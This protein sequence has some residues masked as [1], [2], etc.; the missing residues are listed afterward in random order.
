MLLCI[1]YHNIRQ[2]VEFYH[3]LQ[4]YRR[5]ALMLGCWRSDP[6]QRPNALDI[7]GI[8]TNNENIIQPL[9]SCPALAQITNC[10]E[11]AELDMSPA[12]LKTSGIFKKPPLRQSS[13]VISVDSKFDHIIY[14]FE[15]Q[16]L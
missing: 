7:Y 1:T 4:C 3:S 12:P 14:H 8:L 6:H 13:S 9:L 10:E 16:H 2:V 11:S 5:K 15:K